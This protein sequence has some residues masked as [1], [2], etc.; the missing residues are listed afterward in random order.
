M[1]RRRDHLAVLV[2][3]PVLAVLLTAVVLPGFVP[4]LTPTA[5]AAAAGSTGSAASAPSATA[6]SPT[7]PSPDGS[8]TAVPL[9]AASSPAGLVLTQQTSWITGP[10]QDFDV[11]LETQTPGT[12]ASGLGVTVAVYSCLGTVSALQ[13]SLAGTDVGYVLSRTRNPLPLTSLPAVG[14]TIDLR[15]PVATATSAP[16]APTA[17]GNTPL[18]GFVAE[19]GS[20][21][22]GCG[23]YPVR[24]DLVSLSSGTVMGEL[25]TELVYVTPPPAS[26]KLRF[27]LDIPIGT[28]VSPKHTEPTA[29][30]LEADPLTA[31]D[32]TTRSFAGTTKLI[33]DMAS[34]PP[35]PVTL[36]VVPQTVQMLGNTNETKALARLATVAGPASGGGRQVLPATYVPV[37]AAALVSAGLAGQLADQVRDGR[38][39]LSAAGLADQLAVATGAGVWVTNDPMTA[40]TLAALRSDGYDNIVLPPSDVSP[41][42]TLKTSVQPFP[43]EVAGEGSITAVTSDPGLTTLFTAD[44]RDP[45]LAAHQMLAE[46]AQT[47]FEGPNTSHPRGV[48]AVPPNGWSGRGTLLTNLLD[49]LADSPVVTPVTMSGLFTQV[50]STTAL[51]LPAPRL[52]SSVSGDGT[53]PAGGIRSVQSELTAFDRATPTA[54]TL[55]EQLAALLASAESENLPVRQQLAILRMDRSA[56]AAQLDGLVVASGQAITLTARNGRIPITILSSVKYPVTGTLTLSSDTLLFSDHTTQIS[57]PS[58]TLTS[59]NN[60]IY[61]NVQARVSGEFRVNVTMTTPTG[62]LVLTS[63]TIK[64]ASTAISSVGVVLSLGAIAVLVS[65]WVRTGHRNRRARR[66]ADRVRDTDP[67]RSGI[68]PTDPR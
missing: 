48:V 1:S 2:L 49:G 42:D 54:T 14:N 13:A 55:H 25:N 26:E 36:D 35:V 10:D 12:P 45:V 56:V 63:G 18:G 24:I 23:V 32:V 51:G 60:V 22:P 19:L 28:T 65:W 4:T 20:V 62:N 50:P 68:L 57:V 3:G 9:V 6:S 52:V 47:Y 67:A 33:A 17:A 46:L 15:I 16:S 30:A 37:D 21:Q 43:L 58:V 44:R 41:S 34:A 61:E 5:S 40:S 59:S 11:T 66:A 27:A 7:T 39:A 53:V 38:R 31:L 29:A 64:V 8:G